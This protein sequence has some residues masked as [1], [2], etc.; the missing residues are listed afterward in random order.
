[1]TNSGTLTFERY[2]N[3]GTRSE[4]AKGAYNTNE[5]NDVIISI[6]DG[7]TDVY[8]NGTRT[9]SVDSTVA[10]MSDMLGKNSVAYIGHWDEG[11]YAA[12]YID[13]FV[14]YNY[15]YENPLNSLDLGDLTA[16]TS[17]ITIPTQNGV[18]W[19]TSDAAVVTTAGKITRSDKQ[20][21]LL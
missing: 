4:A 8:V 17:D 10:N 21:Q 12:G 20:K 7:V 14:I 13:D 2:N 9:S 5:W 15:A 16:V 19:S 3:S 1:M 18:T 11:E 6:A